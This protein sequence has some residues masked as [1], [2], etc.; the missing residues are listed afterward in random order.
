[1]EIIAD[2]LENLLGINTTSLRSWKWILRNPNLQSSSEVLASQPHPG[3]R[4]P[5]TPTTSY[6]PSCKKQVIRKDIVYFETYL[7]GSLSP[8]ISNMKILCLNYQGLGIPEA[9][10]ELHCLVSEKCPKVLLLLLLF[11][12]F[13]NLKLV[14]IE[15]G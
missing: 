5:I 6:L 11:F 8:L 4:P 14:W 13:L 15:M 9:V 3:K 7:W 12:F 1:M 2:L 10:K